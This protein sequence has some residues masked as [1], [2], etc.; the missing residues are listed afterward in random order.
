[1]IYLSSSS[2]S[3]KDILDLIRNNENSSNINVTPSDISPHID[4][5][6]LHQHDNDNPTLMSEASTSKKGDSSSLSLS[7]DNLKDTRPKQTQ[8]A[9]TRYGNSIDS[10]KKEV[11]SRVDNKSNIVAK[12]TNR[13][14]ANYAGFSMLSYTFHMR[15]E[16]DGINS[17]DDDYTSNTFKEAI[18]C[19][20]SE[21]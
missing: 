16:D 1:M 18:S 5:R 4:V 9:P 2:T 13:I 19:P 3:S 11:L 12:S 14:S 8:K 10:S 7:D 15:T 6:P 17:C 21:H 20:D